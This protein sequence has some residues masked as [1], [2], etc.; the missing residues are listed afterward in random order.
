M[1]GRKQSQNVFILK[2][3][4][5]VFVY[6][7]SMKGTNSADEA[8][9]LLDIQYHQYLVQEG[10]KEEKQGGSLVAWGSKCL[11]KKGAA[12]EITT[13]TTNHVS[14][15]AWRYYCSCVCNFSLHQCQL[16]THW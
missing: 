6:T 8:N 16:L 14:T 11:E 10:W 1:C 7:R 9:G 4:P 12:L 13:G 3:D 15:I 5:F 2:T